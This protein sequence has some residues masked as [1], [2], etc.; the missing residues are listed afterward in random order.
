MSVVEVLRVIGY[1]PQK[2]ES[3]VVPETSEG[4]VQMV[5]DAINQQAPK[6]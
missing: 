4:L 2:Q 5:V 3:I 1:D 6:V